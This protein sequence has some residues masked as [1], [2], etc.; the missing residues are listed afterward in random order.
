MNRFRTMLIKAS[1]SLFWVAI[2]FLN[3]FISFEAKAQHHPQPILPT[4]TPL[5]ADFDTTN[6]KVYVFLKKELWTY[7]LPDQSWSLE[8]QLKTLPKNLSDLEFGFNPF[9]GKPA[10]WSRGVG[11]VYEIDPSIDTLVRKDLSFD[12]KN[13]FGHIP[14]FRDGK[15]YAFGGYGLW[16]YKNFISVY[17]PEIQEWNLHAPKPTSRLPDPREAK[18]GFYQESDDALYIYGGT[19]TKNNRPDDRYVEK[20]KTEELWKYSFQDQEWQ[21]ITSFG[22]NEWEGYKSTSLSK[23][24]RVNSMSTTAFSPHRNLWYLPFRNERTT[25]MVFHFVPFNIETK[26]VFR[27]IEIRFPNESTFFISNYFYNPKT[28][29]FV[30]VGMDHLTNQ[31]TFPLRIETLSEDSLLKAI[32]VKEPVL[33]KL[34]IFLS[35]GGILLICYLL[36]YRYSSAEKEE[37][38]NVMGEKTAY[39]ELFTKLNN[40]ERRLYHI[41][42]EQNGYT[43]SHELEELAW[44]DIKNYDYHRKLRNETI[45]SIN[46]KFREIIGEEQLLIIRKKDPKDNRRYLYGLNPDAVH[47]RA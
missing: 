22:F 3:L 30:F 9:T 40:Q 16:T 35:F 46:E 47:F 31:K 33:S 1:V 36:W 44:P 10:F 38:S 39:K 2:L 27:P 37:D 15:L 7:Y 21:Y 5:F 43:E 29:S 24:G 28:S 8:T 18:F 34:G 14:F 25:D 45:N 42:K 4:D 20:I 26:E 23:V 13:Q 17:H 19:L 11:S 41:L 6:Q 12:H 32:E